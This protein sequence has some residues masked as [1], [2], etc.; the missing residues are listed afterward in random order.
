MALPGKVYDAYDRLLQA[1]RKVAEEASA[2]MVYL[3]C[4]RACF[5]YAN[6]RSHF[7][8]YL[9]LKD[10]RWRPGK[11][12]E[13]VTI[14]VRAQELIA[15]KPP[16]VLKSTVSV[17]YLTIQD[18]CAK[19][20]HTIHFDYDCPPQ[21]NHPVFHAQLADE[22]VV[23]PEPQ[24]REIRFDCQV[25]PA[26]VPCFGNGRIPTSDMTL[27]SVLLCLAADHMVATFVQKYTK[28]LR[29]IGGNLPTPKC[30]ALRDSLVKEPQNLRSWHWFAHMSAPSSFRHLSHRVG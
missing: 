9:H 26:K 19:L 23:I 1:F 18:Q 15:E 7:E 13:R 8:C 27:S 3:P 14:I 2:G 22:A 11:T 17:S 6:G 10:W 25:D 12:S 16:E 21:D 5:S 30:D 28:S 24:A 4:V 20:L 29:E